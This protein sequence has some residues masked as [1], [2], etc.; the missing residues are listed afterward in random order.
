ML[1]YLRDGAVPASLSRAGRKASVVAALPDG[2]R[3]AVI[4]PG[5]AAVQIVGRKTPRSAR[6]IRRGSVRTPAVPDRR[7]VRRT[8]ESYVK[9]EDGLY[10][11]HDP[12]KGTRRR[13]QPRISL[14]ELLE[15]GPGRPRR[16]RA[17]STAAESARAYREIQF[18]CQ[19][20][21]SPRQLERRHSRRRTVG[22]GIIITKPQQKQQPQAAQRDDHPTARSPGA[23][24]PGAQHVVSR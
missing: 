4:L 14:Q 18:F 20:A 12:K 23:R 8:Q 19:R 21:S 9:D 3:G 16:E 22:N 1:Q 2:E 5:H 13:G 17:C 7:G 15:R 10:Y 6:R 11:A 24:P